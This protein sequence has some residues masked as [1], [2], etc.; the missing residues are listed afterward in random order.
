LG[1]KAEDEESKGWYTKEKSIIGNTDTK[2]VLMESGRGMDKTGGLGDMMMQ[3]E[4]RV[5]FM[6]PNLLLKC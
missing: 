5:T 6:D 2:R 4:V 3:S 1:D